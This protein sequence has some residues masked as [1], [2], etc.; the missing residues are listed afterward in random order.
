[1]LKNINWETEN[2]L[3]SFQEMDSAN[4]N[5]DFGSWF[6]PRFQSL[7]AVILPKTPASKGNSYFGTTPLGK[8][9]LFL[10][11]QTH[12]SLSSSNRKQHHLHML[13]LF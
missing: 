7:Q 12:G 3:Y 9:V 5:T 4:S 13:T 1:M 2:E 11:S 6:S 10:I 8:Q